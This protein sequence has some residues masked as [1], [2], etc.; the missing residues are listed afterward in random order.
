MAKEKIEAKVEE[1]KEEIKEEINEIKTEN[2]T[3][4]KFQNSGIVIFCYALAAVMLVYA[5]YTAFSTVGQITEYYEGYGMTASTSEYITYVMQAALEPLLH[6]FTIFMA[7]Y[8]LNAIRKL[9][10]KNYKSKVELLKEKEEKEAVAAAKA[11][12]RAAK[13]AERAEKEA[14]E[15]KEAADIAETAVAEAAEAE[16]TAEEV[17]EEVA[18]EAA[19]KTVKKT[20]KK[21]TKK[22][23]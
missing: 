6:A 10:P 12:E 15:A 17:A 11:A 4:K 3:E 5:L 8:I 22:E 21:A 19:E 20:S 14:K 9:D 23:D 13:A 16:K 7:G 1:V 18:E 2:L